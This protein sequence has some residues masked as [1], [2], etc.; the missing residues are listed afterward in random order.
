MPTVVHQELLSVKSNLSQP[1]SLP[2]MLDSLPKHF[3]SF[4]NIVKINNMTGKY[5]IELSDNISCRGKDCNTFGSYNNTNDLGVTILQNGLV[6]WNTNSP[7][8]P[9]NWTL[10]RKFYDIGVVATMEFFT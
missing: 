2:C 4:I 3:D 1:S 8:H 7:G 10:G 5:I 6:T 9:R